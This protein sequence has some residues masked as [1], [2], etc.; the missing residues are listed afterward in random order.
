[1]H[2]FKIRNVVEEDFNEISMVGEHCSPMTNERKSI[3][4]MFTRF[5]Q[6]TSMVIQDNVDGKIKG[7]LLGF[8]STDVPEESY[9]HLL[10]LKPSYRGKNMGSKLLDEF[11]KVVS[12]R[13]CRKILLICKPSNKSAIRFYNKLDFLSQKSDKTVEIGD[14]NIFKDYD[15]PKD[16]KIVFYKYIK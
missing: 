10:C 12:A 14:I 8:I 7:F 16:D 1:M 2:D 15:G 11:I 6:Q 5:F 4:H 9:I 3:Y 13:G